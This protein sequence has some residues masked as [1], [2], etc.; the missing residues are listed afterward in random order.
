[1]PLS[2]DEPLLNDD[3][4]LSLGQPPLLVQ[5]HTMRLVDLLAR[6]RALELRVAAASFV[7]AITHTSQVRRPTAEGAG[8]R[9]L[10][11]RVRVRSRG[12]VRGASSV[13][14]AYRL[15]RRARIS[16]SRRRESG[17]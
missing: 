12:V 1:M 14:R 3:A 2:D 16:Q 15:I 4:E 6:K 13:A 17:D 10:I 7:R 5:L 11:R 8:R 9:K